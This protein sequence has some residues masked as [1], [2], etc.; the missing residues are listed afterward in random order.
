MPRLTVQLVELSS[1]VGGY[2]ER[3]GERT[4]PAPPRPQGVLTSL[5]FCL[6]LVAPSGRL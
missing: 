1:W 2:R 3:N 5:S 6:R 4:L